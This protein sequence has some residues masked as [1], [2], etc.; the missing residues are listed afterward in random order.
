MQL[1]L[2]MCVLSGICSI[3][4]EQD[5]KVAAGSTPTNQ[6][7]LKVTRQPPPNCPYLPL[8]ILAGYKGKIMQNKNNFI[9]YDYV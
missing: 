5:N 8:G 7:I 3:P 2:L 1:I 4:A 6:M 9:N